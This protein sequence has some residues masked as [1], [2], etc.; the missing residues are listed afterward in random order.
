MNFLIKTILIIF[1]GF[2]PNNYL[3]AVEINCSSPVHKNK[4]RCKGKD[5]KTSV[6]KDK[7]FDSWFPVAF[8]ENRI[9]SGWVQFKSYEE[10]NENSFRVRGKWTY[11]NNL[12]YIGNLDINC[13][14]KD[15]YF[16]PQG[17]WGSGP[18]WAAIPQGSGIESVAKIFCRRTSAK[19]EWGYTEAT[20]YL[21]DIP[22]P[23]GDPSNLDG[24]WIQHYDR[25]DGEAYYNTAVIK[26]NKTVIYGFF[27]RTK[28]GD[29]SAAQP[30]DNATYQWVNN[31]CTEN[32]ASAF[33]QPDISVS[34]VWLAP[35]PGRPGGSNMIVRKKYCN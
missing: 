3:Y 22:K 29:R 26:N 15:F 10:L 6:N 2:L 17:V 23:I 12:Q 34:G 13:K 33:Y 19:N 20:A 28:K 7:D 35:A 4:P 8:N 1:F 18:N 24:E 21:W 11:P 5:T 31:S 32:L 16:R 25:D 27:S 14:N 9:A 30:L